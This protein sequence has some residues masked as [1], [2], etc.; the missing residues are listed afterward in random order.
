MNGA[1]HCQGCQGGGLVLGPE[2]ACQGNA[3]T[4]EAQTLWAHAWADLTR[5]KSAAQVFWAPAVEQRPAGHEL[6]P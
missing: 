3:H 4:W 2:C 6:V 5:K 1:D